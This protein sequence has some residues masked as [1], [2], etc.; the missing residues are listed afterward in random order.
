MDHNFQGESAC[1]QKNGS[2]CHQYSDWFLM[3]FNLS[4]NSVT[5]VSKFF[6]FLMCLGMCIFEL[7]RL[8]MLN[9]V[10]N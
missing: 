8:V 5:V 9:L 6:T 10:H 4:S 3:V 7:V 2:Q 1:L